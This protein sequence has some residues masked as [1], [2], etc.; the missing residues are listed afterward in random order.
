M[1]KRL[2]WL[3]LAALGA[4]ALGLGLWVTPASG[5]STLPSVT[6]RGPQGLAVLMTWLSEQGFDV[7]AGEAPLTELPADVATVLLP[8]P[9]GSD[10]GDA[11]LDALDGFLARGGTLV[12]LLPRQASQAELARWLG[13]T[14]G[15]LLPLDGVTTLADPGG[16]TVD[17]R[18][19]SGPLAHVRRLRV[20]GA[21]TVTLKGADAL[22]LTAPPA[23]WWRPHG[24]GEVWVA[25]GPDLV[26]NARLDLEDN[27][28][29]WAT[30]AAR[31][32]LWV[33]QSHLRASSTDGFPP[34][35]VAT[36][37]Q[38]LLVGLLLFA[39]GA[40]LG[41][42]RA[43][44]A[45]TQRSSTEYV[46]AM[47]S[48]LGRAHVEAALVAE[49]KTRARRLLQTALGLSPALP[50]REAGLQTAARTT[51]DAAT[52]EALGQA[53]DLLAAT[54]HLAQLESALRRDDAVS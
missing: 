33:D 40:R 38:A 13:A 43:A 53:T 32:P 45:E 19:P 42:P 18:L 24:A 3:P 23:L 8:A 37:L 11:E 34:H 41:P 27:A 28:A 39:A 21:A 6:N 49:V 20:A 12:A 9:T 46:E 48:L 16:L 17:V 22:P 14:R 31:G 1:T 50:W 5:V 26:E 25:A 4:A 10:V 44:P 7:R 29:L 35:L 52:V 15:D 47:A 51:L 2:G 54:R 36:A 30:L